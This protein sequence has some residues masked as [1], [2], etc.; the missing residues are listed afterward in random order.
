MEVIAK[1]E[2]SIEIEELYALL[3]KESGEK[4]TEDT[5]DILTLVR[6]HDGTDAPLR[7]IIEIDDE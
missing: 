1:K 4:I 3:S 5:V 6:R 7:L 2:V